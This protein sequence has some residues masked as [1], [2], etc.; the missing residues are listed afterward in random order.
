MSEKFVIG[1]VVEG[2][3][4]RLK[5]FGAIVSLDGKIQVLV[6]IS[7]VANGFVKDIN[8]HLKE[9][10]TVKVKI[11]SI[12]ETTNRIALSIRDALPPS[13]KPQRTEKSFRSKEQKSNYEGRGPRSYDSP[14]R[15]QSSSNNFEDKMKDWLK[16][17]TE[18]Q[19]T[20]NKRSNK[21]SY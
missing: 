5:P 6:H 12:D 11:L 9:G 10:D 18:R 13:E 16:E 8:D 1:S 3:V 7:Q 17:S 20:L 21:R 2:T 19:A 14:N 15:R 4:V